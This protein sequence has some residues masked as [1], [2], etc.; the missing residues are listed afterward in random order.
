MD[1]FDLRLYS[2]A[3][4]SL[5][6]TLLLCAAL[7]ALASSPRLVFPLLGVNVLLHLLLDALQVKWGN[8]V[9]L[10]AP[11]SWRMTSFE[12]VEGEGALVLGLTVVGGLL[13]AWEIGRRG[14]PVQSFALR[15]RAL[16]MASIFVLAYFV[17]PLP[18]LGAILASDSYSVGT[19]KAMETRTGRTVRFDRTGFV[20]DSS[21]DFIEVWSGERLRVTGRTPER[22]GSVSLEGVFVSPELLRIDRLVE[23]RQSRDWP[24][25]LAL[26]L[27]GLLWIRPLL[28]P[29]TR[30]DDGGEAR[31]A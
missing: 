16:G 9:H 21:G 13:V 27:L 19:L 10:L 7:A 29:S 12:L 1:P 30:A 5:A 18:Y 24:S 26:G 22:E 14:A 20:R 23:H 28:P 4:A 3:Q 17:F 6:G 25:Y 31:T 15:P 2:M 11:F 8:G